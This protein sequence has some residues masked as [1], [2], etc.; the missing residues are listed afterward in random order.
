MT[1]ETVTPPDSPVFHR[2]VS[3][4]DPETRAQLQQRLMHWYQAHHRSLPWRDTGDP[5]HIWVSEV[6]LQ[7]TQVKTVIPYYLAFMAAFPTLKDLADAKLDAVLKHWEGLGYYA[8]ARN[9]HKAARLVVDKFGGHIPDRFAGFKALPGVGDYIAAAVTSIAFGRLRAVVDGNVKRVLARLFCLDT[10]VN[11]SSAHKRFQPLADILLDR[12]D[13]GTFNQAVMELGALVC[14]PAAPDCPACPLAL[15]CCANKK[16]QVIAFPV[17]VARKKTPCH[18][19]STGIVIRQGRLLI[20]C[21]K[22][23]GLLGGLWEFPGGKVKKNET[24]ADACVREIR[25]ETGLTVR[26]SGFLTRVRHAYTHFKIEMDVFFC[27]YASG[28]VVLN[29]PVDYQWIDPAEIRRFAFPKANLKFIDLIDMK[30]MVQEQTDAVSV[31]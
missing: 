31:Q 11:H 24:A 19:I 21:R 3:P 17:K 27:D 9:L 26:I 2:S 7:Q 13:P 20:T 23:D 10:P 28:E 25:E 16:S 14:T 5:Y 15:F 18:H 29:G 22:P 8:R 30:G 6:M 4:V 12:S 1:K